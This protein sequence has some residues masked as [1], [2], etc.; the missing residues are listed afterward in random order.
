MSSFYFVKSLWYDA[1]EMGEGTISESR[2]MTDADYEKAA[3]DP[4]PICD[5]KTLQ[6]FPYGYL[7]NRKAC[8]GCIDRRIKLLE[9]RRRI[10]GARRR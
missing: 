9:N 5:D 2:V 8:K 4:C 3:G 7:G 1:V 10:L 6:L